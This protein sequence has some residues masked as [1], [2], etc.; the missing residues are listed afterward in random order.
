MSNNSP[1]LY[2]DQLS[3]DRIITRWLTRDNIIAWAPFFDDEHST[4]FLPTFVEGDLINR[5]T[6]FI[7]RQLNRYKEKSYGLQALFEKQNETLIGVCGLL[8]QTVEGKEE[9]EVGYH[10]LPARRGKGYAPE[11]ARLFIDFAFSNH[12][13][14]SVISIIN[15]ENTRSQSVA[16]KNGL[17]KDFIRETNQTKEFIYR[18]DR[19]QWLKNQMA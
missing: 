9:I 19:T 11:A 14:D 7:E 4:R 10:I 17:Y 3:S 8:L 18:M 6:A 15:T 2:H 12:L 16:E 13:A 5:S 1:Y